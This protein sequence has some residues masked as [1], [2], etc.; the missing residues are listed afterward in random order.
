MPLQ[1]LQT[2]R[3]D[4]LL[5]LTTKRL[6]HGPQKLLR[7]RH[8]HIRAEIGIALE[9]GLIDPLGQLVALLLEA[10]IGQHHDAVVVLA[11]QDTA[12]ALRRVPHG[13]E[14]EEVVFA[15]AVRLAEELEPRFEDARL[16]VLEGDADAEHGSAVVVVEIDAFGHFAARDAE[17]DGSAAVAAGC[18]VGFECQRGFLGVGCFDEDELV[19]PDLVED[20]HALPHAD[21]GFHVEVGREEDDEAVGGDFAEFVQECAV[22]AD[23]AGVVSNREARGDG[24]LIRAASDDH[25]QE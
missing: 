19:L 11:A 10:A 18:A 21:D 8:G 15:D 22:V 14:G 20:A 1:I 23:H 5:I 12:E 7:A 13:V 4:T 24:G 25:G 6:G 3:T 2:P 17:Q 16:R 9:Q